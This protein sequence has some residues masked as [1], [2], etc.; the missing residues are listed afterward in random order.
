MRA[1]GAN[2]PPLSNLVLVGK[3]LDN[4]PPEYQAA[5]GGRMMKIAAEVWM[6]DLYRCN[7]WWIALPN[8][9]DVGD[10]N[11]GDNL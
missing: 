2:A 4:P 1:G 11:R 9:E 6:T 7:Q 3:I 10:V 5:S 8:V